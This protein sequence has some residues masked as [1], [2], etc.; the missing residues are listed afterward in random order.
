[1]YVPKMY[2]MTDH[3]AILRYMSAHSLGTVITAVN[4]VPNA[5]HLP[6]CWD[7][8]SDGWVLYSHFAEDNP[9]WNEMEQGEVLIVFG[10]ADAYISPRHYNATQNVPT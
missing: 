9:Q 2:E 3:D 4:N 7:A 5:S 8:G 10:G 6:F 1:M